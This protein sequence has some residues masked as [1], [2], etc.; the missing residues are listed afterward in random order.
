MTD[1][2]DR[3]RDRSK[4]GAAR[5]QDILALVSRGDIIAVGDLADRFGVS[6][7]T[8]R[9]DIR[10]LQEAGRLRRVHGGAA[11][12]GTLDLT[13]RRP[14]VERLA[15]DRDAKLLAAAAG[16]ALFGDGMTVFLGGSST[17]LLL[18]DLLARQEVALSVTTNMVDIAMV[19]ATGGRCKVTLLGGVLKPDTRTLTGPDVLRALE[20]RVF[21]LAVCGTSAIDPRR[22][23]LAPSEW[24]AAIGEVLAERAQRL[25][26]VA[27]AGKFGRI[28]AHVV[29]PFGKVSALATDRPP[30]GDMR[31]ALAAAGVG[32]VLPEMA[33]GRQGVSQGA[34]P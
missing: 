23:F 21:D 12:A 2:P 24:H 5:Q 31:D 3:P 11:P 6:Q 14:V 16:L 30:D 19:L 18:A 1:P 33:D 34:R 10:T 7:E 26:F 8:V 32:V 15:M 4:L 27:D 20:R 13:A 25:A 22:G 9:R 17:M 28:D 29:Q